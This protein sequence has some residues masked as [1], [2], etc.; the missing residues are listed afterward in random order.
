M[1]NENLKIDGFAQSIYEVSVTPKE[2]VGTLRILADGRKFRYAQA[3]A[4]DLV[5]GKMSAAPVQDLDWANKACPASAAIGDTELTVTHTAT[6]TAY[7]ADWFRGGY[8]MI[9]DQLVQYPIVSSSAVTTSSTTIDLHL[10]QALMIDL[11]ASHEFRLVASPWRYVVQ[12]ATE[13]CIPTGVPQVAVT[14]AYYCWLQTGG[15]AQCLIDGSPSVGSMLI[16]DATTGAL[17]VVKGTTMDVD[18]PICGIAYGTS[19]D[20]DATAV[21]LILD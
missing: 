14:A 2:M 3:G 4:V 20:D 21:L 11:T 5:A 1:G 17:A 8:L 10:G 13:E 18:A 7:A 16:P 12:N 9:I 15:M 19:Y 6:G